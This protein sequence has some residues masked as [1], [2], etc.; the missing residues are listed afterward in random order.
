MRAG[1]A[2]GAFSHRC[3]PCIFPAA[4]Q[5]SR[6]AAEQVTCFPAA[7]DTEKPVDMLSL[8]A[9]CLSASGCLGPPDPPPAPQP[10]WAVETMWLMAAVSAHSSRVFP[11][12]LQLV[13]PGA[14]PP[15]PK[16]A[17]SRQ[18]LGRPEGPAVSWENWVVFGTAKSCTVTCC[19]SLEGGRG[20]SGS[21]MRGWTQRQQGK[22]S[23]T[24]AC[25]ECSAPADTP[26]SPKSWGVLSTAASLSLPGMGARS[27]TV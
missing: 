19:G 17:Q 24:L 6:Q 5:R 9:A 7:P 11:S 12:L 20:T 4:L 27:G 21:P 2:S 18:V 16:G 22:G 13:P 1:G 14:A 8:Q 3:G 15:E 10:V 23:A 25:T 26:Q